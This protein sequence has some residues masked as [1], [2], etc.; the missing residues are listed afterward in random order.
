MVTTDTVLINARRVTAKAASPHY[1]RTKPISSFPLSNQ[2][3]DYYH[4]SKGNQHEQARYHQGHSRKP[5]S[6]CRARGK[7][8]RPHDGGATQSAQGILHSRTQAQHVQARTKGTILHHLTARN[9]QKCPFLLR[10]SFVLRECY[11]AFQRNNY[12]IL[13]QVCNGRHFSYEA[14]CL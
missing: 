4:A 12:G 7:H 2:R 8:I 14:F 1:L 9:G 13:R 6:Q 11:H 3:Q 10:V 5:K